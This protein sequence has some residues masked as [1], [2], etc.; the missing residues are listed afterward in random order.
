MSAPATRIFRSVAAD[1]TAHVPSPDRVLAEP[2]P[3]SGLKGVPGNQG[4]PLIGHAFSMFADALN[5]TRR[6]YAEYGPVCWGGGPGTPVVGVTG[7]D[8]IGEVLANREKVFLNAPGWNFFIGPFFKGGL[9]LMDL[10]EHLFHRR[11][12]QQA[13][14]HDRLVGYLE[15]MNPAIA[16]GLDRWAVNSKIALYPEAKR[17]TL[18]IAT[19]V[20]MGGEVGAGAD[21]LNKAF[22][23][24][25]V[26]GQALVRADVPGGTWH[27]GLEARKQL[28]RHFYE[29]LPA[30]RASAGDDLFS[31]LCHAESEEGERFSDEEVVD[32][33]IFLLMAAHDTSTITVSM[34][35]Y[36]LGRYPGWQERLRA[37]SQAL[38]KTAVTHA[39]LETLTDLDLVMKET[40]RMN[41]PV[42]IIVREAARDTSLQGF[43]IP[44]GTRLM[45][46]IYAS[47]RM[48]EWW[49]NADHFDPE[50]FSES[51]R[52]DRSNQYAWIPF[53]GN[54]HKCIGMHFGGMEVK[55]IIH[56]MLLR[57]RWSVP[58]D[59]EP[60]LDYGT[61]PM[62]GDG[63]PMRLQPLNG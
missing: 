18:D 4:V 38:G 31:V 16:R 41:A 54:V 46:N 44:A 51:R 60:P 20:F 40:L 37:Q 17:L 42:G 25:V 34:M 45:L 47:Q 33:M 8:A 35:A 53:G 9:M 7:P 48:N 30:K 55:A 57:Y 6:R 32:H 1:I 62:P 28:E 59:Y 63:L 23:D 61:G 26:G 3:G 2:P 49:E 21:K 24:A 13:F 56:Q 36:F 27:R 19:E 52:E 10:E 22:V 29:Q 50:R 58:A 11:I 39:E 15:G 5:H 12:M 14:K 43:Y